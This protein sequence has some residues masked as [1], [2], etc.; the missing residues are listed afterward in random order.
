M[1]APYSQA[2]RPSHLARDATAEDFWPT[3]PGCITAW[4]VQI[5]FRNRSTVI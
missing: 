2:L 5:E 4:F 3:A 1:Y